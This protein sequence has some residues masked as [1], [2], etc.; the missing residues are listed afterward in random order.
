MFEL[1]DKYR[2]VVADKLNL[3]LE[4]LEEVIELK[5]KKPTGEFKWKNVA[6]VGLN[7]NHAIKRYSKEVI[8]DGIQYG[9]LMD[10]LKKLEDKIDRLPL[11]DKIVFVP[12][13]RKKDE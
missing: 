12:K 1:D 4:K 2:V 13:E 9:D 7:L 8:R 11:K 6:Y 3:S 10:R 5:T